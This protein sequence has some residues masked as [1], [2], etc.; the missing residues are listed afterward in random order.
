MR[1]PPIGGADAAPSWYD[2]YE[3]VGNPDLA[4]DVASLAA[5]AHVGGSDIVVDAHL[6]AVGTTVEIFNALGPM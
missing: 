1:A 4:L 5:F 2:R 3:E 6:I